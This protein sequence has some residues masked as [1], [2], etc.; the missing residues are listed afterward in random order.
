MSSFI[1]A[2]LQCDFRELRVTPTGRVC[3]MVVSRN[4]PGNQQR[5]AQLLSL[6]AHLTLRRVFL[7]VMLSSNFYWLL[8]TLSVLG[9]HFKPKAQFCNLK[10]IFCCQGGA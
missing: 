6:S 2:M 7:A 1:R 9:L 5:S 8:V 10:I 3:L 4:V